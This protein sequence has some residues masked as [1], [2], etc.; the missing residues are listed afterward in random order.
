MTDDAFVREF[1]RRAG[2][3]V[4]GDAGTMTLA[5]LSAAFPAP[6][7]PSLPGLRTPVP[8]APMPASEAPV[9]GAR[10]FQGRA[11]VREI[12]I[13][14]AATRPEWMQ[15]SSLA[16][17]RAEIRRWHLARGFS[18]IGYHWLIDRDGKVMAGRLESVVGSHVKGRNTGT[19]GICL[20]GG[21]GSATSDL[22][23]EHFTPEQDAALRRLI[24]E[25]QG[26]ANIQTI[27]G[28]SQYANKAC[29]G[30]EVDK[31]LRA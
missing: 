2:V 7:T 26:R 29:P 22:F 12:I 20:I 27:S 31:W 30:F 23:A 18:D 3:H 4:D 6:V 14:C 21:H 17:K 13:H 10:L 1:Q 24:R 5:A 9:G 19:L 16:T 11:E 8:V 15:E 25:I 28:H